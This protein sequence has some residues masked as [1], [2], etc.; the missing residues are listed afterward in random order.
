[1][2]GYQQE[3]KK[4]QSLL[5]NSNIRR[6]ILH[7]LDNK[8]K[9]SKDKILTVIVLLLVN[10]YAKTLKSSNKSS[11]RNKYISFSNNSQ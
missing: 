11:N 2:E 4:K 10:S 5:D 3:F 8:D 6:L 9:L 7:L 1:M